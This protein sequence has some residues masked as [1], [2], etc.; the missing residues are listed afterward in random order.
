MSETGKILIADDEETFLFSIADLL[1]RESFECTCVKDAQAAVKILRDN[2]HDLLIAD[3]KMP[4]N[5]ELELIQSL[6]E[7]A[8]GM[9]VILVTGYPSLRSAI[10]SV[11]LPVVSY[12]VKPVDFDQ[13]LTAVRKSIKNFQVYKSVRSARRRLDT[14]RVDLNNLDELFTY[15]KTEAPPVDMGTY[16]ELTVRNISGSLLDLLNLAET[17]DPASGAKNACQL[18]P[19]PRLT[20]LQEGLREAVAILEKTKHAFKSK[21]LGILRR[22]LANLIDA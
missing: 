15:S 2:P 20:A 4:G 3:I 19:C 21:D 6:P 12:I 9:P 1:R 16:L 10:E 22:K 8:K 17:V 18:T 11:N 5:T 14:L 7:S 13:L